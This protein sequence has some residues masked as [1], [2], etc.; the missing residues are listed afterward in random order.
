MEFV[1]CANDKKILAMC[2]NFFSTFSFEILPVTPDISH[3]AAV[4]I[5]QFSLS[6]NLEINDAL[7]AATAF[8]YGL[9]LA[10]SNYK[11]YKMIDGLEISR[12]R[13]D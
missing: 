11:D 13:I 7:I 4:F 8:E 1:Q 3:R 10:T 2:K 5:E 12:L 6:Y 9:P